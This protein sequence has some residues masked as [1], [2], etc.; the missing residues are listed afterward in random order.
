MQDVYRLSRATV[1]QAVQD[2]ERAGL[3]TRQ[4]GRGTFVSVP[5]IPPSRVGVG[6]TLLRRG[7]QPGWRVLLA[8]PRPAPPAV[9]ARLQLAPDADAFHSLR[10]RLADGCPIG[11]LTAHVPIGLAGELDLDRLA[12]GASLDYLR[13]RGLLRR[14]RTVRTI[15]AAAADPATAANL[16]IPPGS[17]VL[18]VLRLVLAAD[19]RPLE[20]CCASYRP[21]RFQLALPDTIE[22]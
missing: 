22:P 14:S 3:V 20:D 18:Q 6:E 11:Q 4:R 2:L 12:A 8:E 5:V 17:P 7:H 21:D 1:R 16:E 15:T 19:G 10:L 13:A 9:A